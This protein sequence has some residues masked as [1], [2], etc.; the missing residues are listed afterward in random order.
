MVR[1]EIESTIWA[2]DFLDEEERFDMI[3]YIE[4]FFN[5]AENERF[6]DREISVTC[7]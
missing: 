4:S 5:T 2:F 3:G 1:D 7:K 6:I